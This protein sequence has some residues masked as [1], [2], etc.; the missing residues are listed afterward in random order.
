[1]QR[2]VFVS[3][4]AL[5]GGAVAFAADFWN[6]KEYMQWTDE[7]VKKVLT[8]SPWAK[9]VTINAPITVVGRGQR[10]PGQSAAGTDEENGGGGA[11]AGRRGGGRS[12]SGFGDD[13]SSAGGEALITLN[14][15]W[16]SAR[17]LKKALIRSRL[18]IAAPVPAEAQKLITGDEEDYVIVVSGVPAGMASLFQ[19]PGTADKSTIRGGKKPPV[20][21]KSV[22]LQPRTNSIDVVFLFPKTKSIEPDDKEVEVVLMFGGIE[23]KKKFSLKD[24]VY[25]GKLEL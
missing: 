17:P 5:L 12:S 25:D 23:A 20:A 7:E 8:N 14:I 22:N 19:N 13:G 18:G 4:A 10:S 2:I 16:R 3:L 21:A 15:S 11:R 24:M 1:M 9:D 6:T